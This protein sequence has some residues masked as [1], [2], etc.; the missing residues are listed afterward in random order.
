MDESLVSLV[1]ETG[2]DLI[3]LLKRESSTKLVQSDKLSGISYISLV[4]SNKIDKFLQPLMP[5]GIAFILF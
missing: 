1:K 2:I 5:A 4:S 3:L